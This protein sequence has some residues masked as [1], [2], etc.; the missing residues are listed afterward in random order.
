[1]T[2]QNV[3]YHSITKYSNIYMYDTPTECP[4]YCKRSA[5]Y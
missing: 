2:S 5:H 3:Y 1:M 4:Y